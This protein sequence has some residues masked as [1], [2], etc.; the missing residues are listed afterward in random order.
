MKSKIIIGTANFSMN[1]GLLKKKAK[2][3]FKLI[4]YLSKKNIKSYDISNSY[5][6][7]NN[8]LNYLIR[9]KS[10]RFYLKL[11]INKFTTKENKINFKKIRLL[12]KNISFRSNIMSFYS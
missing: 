7:K 9:E 11:D 8:V 1:Y 3:I 2:N 5:N 12:Y 6:L 10:N 4:D